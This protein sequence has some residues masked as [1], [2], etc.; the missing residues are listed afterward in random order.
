[1]AM[2]LKNVHEG[3]QVYTF[4]PPI[5]V[6]IYTADDIPTEYEFDGRNIGKTG[7]PMGAVDPTFPELIT[8]CT[9]TG[10]ISIK[11]RNRVNFVDLH[12]QARYV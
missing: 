4:R 3:S 11:I 7:R 6:Q 12:K 1:M 2:T 10:L 5:S 8:R 9:Q